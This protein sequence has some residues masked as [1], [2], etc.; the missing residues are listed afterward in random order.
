MDVLTI[1]KSHLSTIPKTI[2]LTITASL[3]CSVLC[4][5]MSSPTLYDISSLPS[6][7]TSA[8]HE[9]LNTLF[10][11]SHYLRELGTPLLKEKHYSS[12]SDLI[13]AVES[14]LKDLANTDSTSPPKN[15]DQNEDGKNDINVLYD[16]LGSHPRLG[17]SSATKASHLSELSKREQANLNAASDARAQ[18]EAKQLMELNRAYEDKFPGLRYVY[19]PP[20]HSS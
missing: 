8:H 15:A 20:V 9:I 16:I 12:Y 18:E 19:V 10:E 6:L 14:R 17:A 1:Q 13:D 7:P 4:T 2:S 11:P 5:A 3:I